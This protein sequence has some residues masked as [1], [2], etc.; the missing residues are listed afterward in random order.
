[1]KGAPGMDGPVPGALCVGK[2]LTLQVTLS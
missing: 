2:R 1:M